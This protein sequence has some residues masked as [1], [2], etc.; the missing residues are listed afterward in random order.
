V[1]KHGGDINVDGSRIAVA[2]DSVGGNMAAAVTLMAKERS[3]PHLAGQLLFYP[4][5]DANFNNGSYRLFAGGP[6]L[7]R[8]AMHRRGV[9]RP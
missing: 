6:W 8:K 5:T 4:V 1:A 3:G 9:A 7:T 2:G